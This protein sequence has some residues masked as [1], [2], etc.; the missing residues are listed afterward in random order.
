[1]DGW[2][3]LL[4]SLQERWC[5]ASFFAMIGAPVWGVRTFCVFFWHCT[6]IIYFWHH[7]YRE[8]SRRYE[9]NQ[10]QSSQ[11]SQSSIWNFTRKRP[12]SVV[13]LQLSIIEATSVRTCVLA[14]K[15]LEWPCD[16]KTNVFIDL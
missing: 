15:N 13:V 10:N 14:T 2:F 8:M 11:S 7:G 5:L 12:P 9:W 16:P 3:V 1:L 6:A 4:F